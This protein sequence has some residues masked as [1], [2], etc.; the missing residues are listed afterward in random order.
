MGTSQALTTNQLELLTIIYAIEEF[1]KKHGNETAVKEIITESDLMSPE[2]YDEI[3]DILSYYGYL[4]K[5]E[6]VTIDGKQY[7]ALYAEYLQEKEKNPSIAINN[8]FALINIENLNIGL[9]TFFNFGE[10]ISLFKKISDG[11][12][13]LLPSK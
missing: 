6:E 1:G 13:K 7:I 8:S 5:Y 4:N 3:S 11:I 9:N 10:G 12:K 2:E